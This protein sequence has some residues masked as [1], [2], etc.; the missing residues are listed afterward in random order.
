MLFSI[1]FSISESIIIRMG[2]ILFAEEDVNI[3][4]QSADGIFD[5][6]VIGV[7]GV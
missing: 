7:G 1:I 6:Y 5:G 3:S 2:H 4:P